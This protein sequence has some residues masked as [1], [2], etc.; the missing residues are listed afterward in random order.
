MEG[1]FS[2]AV[3]KSPKLIFISLKRRTF[4]LIT[5]SSFL[6]ALLSRICFKYSRSK[7][8]GFFLNKTKL[9][10]YPQNIAHPKFHLRRHSFKSRVTCHCVTHNTIHISDILAVLAR[11]SVIL[12]VSAP[13]LAR[14]YL[15]TSSQLRYK[16]NEAKKRLKLSGTVQ[17]GYSFGKHC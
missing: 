12:L 1:E 16:G 6:S 14:M 3:I 11:D 8:V 10:A 7:A 15:F 4:P 5:T 13:K 2:S 9:F 17:I